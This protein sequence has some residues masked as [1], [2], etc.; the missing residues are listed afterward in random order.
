MSKR[1]GAL[2]DLDRWEVMMRHPAV[3]F[4]QDYVSVS[5]L[6]SFEQC[7]GKFFFDY[8][9]KGEGVSETDSRGADVGKV[10]HAA[11]QGVYEWVTKEEFSGIIPQETISACY[12]AAFT[13]RDADAI[14][15]DQYEDGLR[16]TH[17]YFDRNPDVDC[18]SVL[19]IEQEFMVEI[20]PGIRIK[21][22]MDRVDV[23]DGHVT[24]RDYKTNANLYTQEELDQSL[25]AGVYLLVARKLWPWAKSYSFVF[26]M[27]KHDREQTTS[28]TV[29]DLRI[30][31]QYVIDL[32]ARIERP[33]PEWKRKLSV[34]CGWCKHRDRC[35]RFRRATEEGS[36][37]VKL[38]KPEEIDRIAEERRRLDE[39]LK[40]VEQRKKALD[41]ILKERIL[42]E[43]PTGQTEIVYPSVTYRIINVNKTT[44]PLEETSQIL[45]KV[46]KID[47]E[48]ARKKLVDPIVSKSRV[49]GVVKEVREELNASQ[50]AN[51]SMQ[52]AAIMEQSFWFSK[53]DAKIDKGPKLDKPS[54]KPK[55][56]PSADLKCGF[57][58]KSPAK[59]VERGGA[60]FNVCDEHKNKRKPPSS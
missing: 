55:A 30:V 49:D 45:A 41:K 3:G 42:Q 19:A 8:V 28:R 48:E 23:D 47:V 59:K 34:L 38:S 13:A 4:V 7:E 18:W 53:L 56:L 46:M 15:L 22:F 52:L 9:E 51:L 39:V 5:R 2:A 54:K 35:D 16:L 27:L 26:D 37:I 6:Q 17:R 21:G 29:A 32:V 24:I 31:R 12:R 25:Q 40:A 1:H 33:F 43:D 50:R 11:L 10:T 60:T 20:A 44:Y 36:E 58:G 14:G 57:C